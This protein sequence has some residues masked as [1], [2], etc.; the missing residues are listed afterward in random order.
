M[1]GFVWCSGRAPGMYTRSPDKGIPT[2]KVRYGISPLSVNLAPFLTVRLRQRGFV[3]ISPPFLAVFVVNVWHGG[4]GPALPDCVLSAFGIT[5]VV[6]NYFN[7]FALTTAN[8]EHMVVFVLTS[9]FIWFL[10]AVRRWPE[11]VP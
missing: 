1:V 3:W 9:L 2:L 8:R 5:Y 6:L 10:V 7:V 11:P 4:F